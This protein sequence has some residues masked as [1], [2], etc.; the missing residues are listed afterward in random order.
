MHMGIKRG[1]PLG[2]KKEQINIRLLD[3]YACLLK[4]GSPLYWWMRKNGI[5]TIHGQQKHGKTYSLNPSSVITR[6]LHD[7]MLTVIKDDPVAFLAYDYKYGTHP[8]WVNIAARTD[9]EGG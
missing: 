3:E 5:R 4:R 9:A 2:E 7:T 8:K 6:L 1:R